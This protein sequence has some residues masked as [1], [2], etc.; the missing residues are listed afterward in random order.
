M[1]IPE[2]FI[3][4]VLMIAFLLMVCF[5]IVALVLWA[6]I[7]SLSDE[8]YCLEKD[9][10]NRKTE[11]KELC[12][13][14]SDKQ[15]ELDGVNTWIELGKKS[16]NELDRNNNKLRELVE[17]SKDKLNA[18][19]EL[20]QELKNRQA[21]LEEQLKQKLENERLAA[22]A[23]QDDAY[24]SLTERNIEVLHEIEVNV[25][26]LN[27]LK[28]KQLAYIRERAR[29]EE[30]KANQD[31]YRL[32]IDEAAENDIK[33][34]RQVQSVISKKDAIDKI[35][36]SLYYKP[37]YDV[38]VSHLFKTAKPCGIY[39]ITSLASG[40]VYI[41]QSVDC[42]TRF[43]DHIKAGIAYVPS[44]NK[45]YQAMHKE[46]VEN[47]LFELLEEVPR[48]KL[49]EREIYWI[50]FYDTKNSGLNVTKGGS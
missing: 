35:L 11:F 28:S 23:E 4:I 33:I 50:E 8:K 16:L 22:W 40:K 6:K 21:E 47:F 44:A 9:I 5:I 41:G 13:Q 31:F 3:G 48:E 26:K 15:D 19:R 14:V 25:D 29:Q 24:N 2:H 20:E 42:A 38:L 1:A 10:E 27:D 32:V 12:F 7:S 39:K 46:G 45:L 49:N 17:N 43:S 18:Y 36:W 37:A 34:L 30:L